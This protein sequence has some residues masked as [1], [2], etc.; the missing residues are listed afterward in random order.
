M[1][2]TEPHAA[3]RKPSPLMIGLAFITLLLVAVTVFS[4]VQSLNG[5]GKSKGLLPPES[6]KPTTLAM[7]TLDGKE[8]SLADHKGR[9]VLV[10]YFATWCPPCVHEMPELRKVATE[11][12]PRGLDGAMVS[13][14]KDADRNR[15]RE[16]VLK[17]FLS[18]EPLPFPILLPPPESPV[19]REISTIPQA[20]LVDK[21]GR[22]A[23]HIVG[24]VDAKTLRPLIE[25]L[26]AE[27]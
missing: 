26:L 9:V 3:P 16:D 24:A 20:F 6:R 19:I 7:P 25:K 15:P 18:Y 5:P 10:N 21:Q 14:D 12:A 17:E 27:P 23:W 22:I 8:W 11:F 2:M 1:P 4:A 13:L